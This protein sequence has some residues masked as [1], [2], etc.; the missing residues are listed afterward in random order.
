MSVRNFEQYTS[1]LT[2]EELDMVNL[3]VQSFRKKPEGTVWTSK[4]I[5][6]GFRNN[7][8][9]CTSPRVRKIVSYIRRHSIAP[10][11][12]SSNGYYLSHDREEI[13][14]HIVSLEDRIAGIRSAK[15]GLS[16]FL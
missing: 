13:R 6:S 5:I 4:Q 11:L 2:T 16:A 1:D 8:Y 9:T 15:E 12:A 14:R 3:L 7:G 10:I